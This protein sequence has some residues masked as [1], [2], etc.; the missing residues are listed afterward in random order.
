M[1]I[2]DMYVP[3]LHLKKFSREKK[4]MHHLILKTVRA[5]LSDNFK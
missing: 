2:W 1:A 4:Q 3:F 5:N